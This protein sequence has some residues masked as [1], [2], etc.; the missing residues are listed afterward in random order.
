MGQRSRARLGLAGMAVLCAVAAAQGQAM[1]GTGGNPRA[2]GAEGKAV[3]GGAGGDRAT[4]LG[5]G[6]YTDSIGPGERLYYTV[7]LDAKSSAFLSATAAPRPG[8]GVASYGDGI[9]VRLRSSSGEHCSEKSV[10]FSGGDESYPIADYASRTMN[11]GPS[12]RCQKAGPYLF[13]VERKGRESSDAGR[14][15]LEIRFVNE[16]GAPGETTTPPAE[17]S[18]SSD[19]PVPPSGTPKRARGGSGFNDAGPIADGVWK[20]R[21][22]PGE[23]RFYRVPVDWGRQLFAAAEIPDTEK[24]AASGY[25]SNAVG[26]TLHNPARG[27]VTDDFESYRGEQVGSAVGTAPVAYNNRF[28]AQSSVSAVRFAGWYYLAVTVHRDVTQFFDGE[29]PVTL[30]IDV[31]GERTAAPEYDGDAAEAGFAVTDE[32][33][34]AAKNGTAPAGGLSAGTL[35]VIGAAGIGTGTALALGLAGWTLVAR[36]RAAAGIPATQQP[37][38]QEGRFGPPPGW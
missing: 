10:G 29:V 21:V 37:P 2:Y 23:T 30:R 28:D 14:W 12:A 20:D 1:A 24:A 26:L 34:E 6:Q 18:W 17:G 9:T 38:P 3:H 16:P 13:S 25:V 7:D 36:R 33:L 32:D 4:P 11:P 22:R 8:T 31:E 5:P 27:H 19:P 15:P 35:R